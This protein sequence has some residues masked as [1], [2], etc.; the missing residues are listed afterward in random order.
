MAEGL[1]CSPSTFLSF[2][3]RNLDS[4]IQADQCAQYVDD[5]DIAAN[6][7]QQLIK[8]LRA[9][10]QCP[11]KAGHK[12]SMAKCHFGVQEVHFLG[13]RVR[14]ERVAPQKQKIFAKEKTKFLEKVKF[15]KSE[16]ALQRYIGLLNLYQNY[17]TRLAERLAQFF[18]L[19]KTTDAKAK[20]PINPAKMKEI[21][22]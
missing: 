19:I 20:I 11:K 18:Q 9:V 17:L 4:A 3:R 6:I 10:F 12:L 15:L 13:F 16:K 2:V 22:E 21:R 5:I 14:T 8:N 7:F 1:S